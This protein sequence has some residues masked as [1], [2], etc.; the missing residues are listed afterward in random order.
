VKLAAPT[1]PVLPYPQW[2]MALQARGFRPPSK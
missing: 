1:A 2:M